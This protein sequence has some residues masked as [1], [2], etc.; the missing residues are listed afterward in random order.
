MFDRTEDLPHLTRSLLNR[1]SA[2]ADAEAV[3]K[4]GEGRGPRHDDPMLALQALDQA[5][6]AQR[7]GV[8]AF[9]RKKEDREIGRQRWV[10]VLGADVFGGVLNRADEG[11]LRLLHRRRIAVLTRL[12]EAQVIL[13]GE[14]GIDGQPH[15]LLGLVARARKSDRK[16][17]DVTRVRPWLDVPIELLGRENL[18]EQRTELNLAPCASRL[19]V[20][21][22]FLEV[23]HPTSKAAHLPETLLHRLEPIAD[24]LE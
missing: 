2:E 6:V 3:Q 22:H 23:A 14:L 24:E 18:L 7:F 10:Q 8:E 1:E 17:D 11:A 13:L 9:R 16:L 20:G 12:D 15:A 19:D 5:G 4:G 21:E